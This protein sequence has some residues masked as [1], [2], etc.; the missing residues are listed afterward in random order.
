MHAV[1]DLETLTVSA[2]VGPDRVATMRAA[3]QAGKC[4]QRANTPGQ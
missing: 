2:N 3:S 4:Q 1:S